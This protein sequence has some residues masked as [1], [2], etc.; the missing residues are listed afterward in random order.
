[1]FIFVQSLFLKVKF[2]DME[3]TANAVTFRATYKANRS[4]PK[5]CNAM[6]VLRDVRLFMN[7]MCMLDEFIKASKRYPE[8]IA[9]L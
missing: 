8:I 4:L 1:M 7:D 6:A 2:P 9:S 5:N 3:L